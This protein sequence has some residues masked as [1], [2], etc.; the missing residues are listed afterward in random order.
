M[1][2]K[3]TIVRGVCL[4]GGLGLMLAAILPAVLVYHAMREW[5]AERA[6]PF[7]EHSIETDFGVLTPLQTAC[8]FAGISLALFVPGAAACAL[9][10]S[11]HRWGARQPTG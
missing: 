5:L 10:L 4:V 11:R 2:S 8:L 3:L 1:T 7:V 9:A 6:D